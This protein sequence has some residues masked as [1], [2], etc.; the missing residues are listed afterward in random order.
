MS[1]LPRAAATVLIA[2][3]ALL[4]G[5]ATASAQPSAAAVGAHQPANDGPYGVDNDAVN[6]EH[7]EVNVAA[8]SDMVLD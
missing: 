5:A 6:V 7:H 1:R 4:G 3:L 2:S 8:F